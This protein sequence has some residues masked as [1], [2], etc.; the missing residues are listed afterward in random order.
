MVHMVQNRDNRNKN[1]S[2]LELEIMLALLKGEN[3][4]RALAK[5]LNASHSTVSRILARL[6]SENVLDFKTEGKNKVFYIKKNLQAK[7]YVFNA[8]R[9]KLIRLIKQ[10]PELGIIIE[11]ILKN[12]NERMII[13]FGSFAKGTAKKDSDIDIY[14]ETTD[15]KTKDKINAL[16]SKISIKIGSFDIRDQLIK[17]IIKN[18]VILKGADDFYDGLGFFE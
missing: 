7:N 5:L 8:E 9:Y 6:L 18:H 14:I 17:E 15:R 1:K 2:N 10:Y 4:L 16:H 3:H 11:T 12:C 13:L